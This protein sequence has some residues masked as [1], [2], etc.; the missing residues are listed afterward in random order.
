MLSAIMCP[1]P[2]TGAAGMRLF[3]PP[4]GLTEAVSAPHSEQKRT[5][6]IRSSHIPVDVGLSGDVY[7]LFGA[8]HALLIVLPD[9][10]AAGFINLYGLPIAVQA[11]VD[12]ANK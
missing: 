8:V 10:I 7:F 11:M 5:L 3:L 9:L 4:C 2:P 1:V 12:K 6:C